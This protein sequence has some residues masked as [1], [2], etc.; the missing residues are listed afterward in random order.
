M[1]D[2]NNKTLAR[3]RH[4]PARMPHRKHGG[5]PRR[6]IHLIK[7]EAACSCC[8]QGP[9]YGTMESRE[10]Q[11]LLKTLR[12]QWRREG[13][14]QAWRHLFPAL[15]LLVAVVFLG[16]QQAGMWRWWQPG[17]HVDGS[18][19]GDPGIADSLLA[20]KARSE[21]LRPDAYAKGF[22]KAW[23]A[24]QQYHH[25]D[26]NASR[27]LI[28]TSCDAPQASQKPSP[29]LQFA[30]RMDDQAAQAALLDAYVLVFPLSA[31][32]R[33]DASRL[34]CTHHLAALAG[35]ATPLIP[36]CHLEQG[37]GL[38]L[39][40]QG[41]HRIEADTSSRRAFVRERRYVPCV[42]DRVEQRYRRIT[43]SW[44][45]A[46]GSSHQLLLEDAPAYLVQLM[47]DEWRLLGAGA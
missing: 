23:Q 39:L 28:D 19:G 33:L 45:G 16:G 9:L 14:T 42:Q 18:L 29:R 31:D 47:Q 7:A 26:G 6:Q 27:L 3:K 2:T 20:A 44:R 11:L 10:G 34:M 8:G 37:D 5:A 30:M 21:G 24:Y 35:D 38:H 36:R 4:G 17:H 25:M 40:L 12:A 15:L 46:D 22:R 43:L 32:V 41:H 1:A 13:Y